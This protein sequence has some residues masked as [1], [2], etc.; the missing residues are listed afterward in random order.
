[1]RRKRGCASSTRPWILSRP[2]A[3]RPTR[4]ARSRFSR[5]RVPRRPGRA[6]ATRGAARSPSAAARTAS[7]RPDSSPSSPGSR[8][9]SRRPR[10]S[11]R[12]TTTGPRV[13]ATFS[14]RCRAGARSRLVEVV[15]DFRA[16]T[17]NGFAGRMG[18]PVAVSELTDTH[19]YLASLVTSASALGATHLFLA[20]ENEV[21]ENVEFD[22]RVVQHTHFM[23]A[24]TTLRRL[25]ALCSVPPGL[26][27]PRS[28]RLFTASRSCELLW[29]RYPDLA[30]LQYSCWRVGPERSGVQPLLPMPEARPRDAQGRRFARARRAS[31]FRGCSSRCATSVP[32]E[33]RARAPCRTPPSRR[34]L[35]LQTARRD[36][37]PA[38]AP[39]RGRDH[40]L[41]PGRSPRDARRTRGA[42]RVAAPPPQERGHLR[43]LRA[44]LEAR[45]T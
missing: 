24:A 32:D 43:R 13:A 10:R 4:R 30:D 19:L 9:S 8:S 27:S 16:A 14:P 36:P 28:R 15:S 31:T 38:G 2:C 26:C 34:R 6:R 41:G 20:S 21:Q 42:P 45:P 37:G 23:Y 17:D 7:S 1:M 25:S 39:H 29:K 44:R 22:G 3:A 40:P 35:R 5:E 33:R 18:Y 12:S 11:R